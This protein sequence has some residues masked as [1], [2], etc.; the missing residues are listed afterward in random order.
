MKNK[1]DNSTP[2]ALHP[3]TQTWQDATGC[4]KDGITPENWQDRTALYNA[5]VTAHDM[6]IQTARTTKTCSL[7]TIEDNIRGRLRENRTGSP[8]QKIVLTAFRTAE[9]HLKEFMKQQR[10]KKNSLQQ[11]LNRQTAIAARHYA[12]PTHEAA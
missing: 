1:A 3:F 2:D 6:V 8:I 7:A 11:E 9:P 5:F 10:E 12:Q 4:L